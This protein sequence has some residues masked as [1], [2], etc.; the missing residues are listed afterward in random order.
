M[1]PDPNRSERMD[2]LAE[3]AVRVVLGLMIVEIAYSLAA[4]PLFVTLGLPKPSGID[5]GVF[6]TLAGLLLGLL[7]RGAVV[8]LVGR[9]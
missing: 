3:L 8:R 9:K 7:G 4:P 1:S 5:L 6:G 2:R